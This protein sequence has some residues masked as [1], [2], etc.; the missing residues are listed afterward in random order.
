MD[1][2]NGEILR[3]CGFF[4]GLQPGKLARLADMGRLVPYARGRTI[5]RQD[6]PCPGLFVV[7]SGLV[8]VFKTAPSGKEHVLHFAEPGQTFAEVAVI[9]RFNC[10]AHAEAVEDSTCLLLPNQAF[11]R[12]LETDHELCLQLMAGMALWVRRLVGLL[13]DLA[14]RDATGR[15]ARHLLEAERHGIDGLSFRLPMLKKDLASHLNLT[16]ETLSRTFRRL[17]DGGLIEMIDAQQL[18][19]LDRAALSEVADGLLPAE[20][21]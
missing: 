8:R 11:T 19:I 10:P 16:S 18:R 2:S 5:F 20:F 4:K 9:G 21:Y 13:E 15:V 14:L 17:I 6:D 3:N 7:G 1:R 12:A